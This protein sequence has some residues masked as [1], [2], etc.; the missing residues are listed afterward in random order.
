MLFGGHKQGGSDWDAEKRRD[1]RGL[2][3]MGDS[4]RNFNTLNIYSPS[5]HNDFETVV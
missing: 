5:A 3:T 2:S 4:I 1:L